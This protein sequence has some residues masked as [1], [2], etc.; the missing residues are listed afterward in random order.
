MNFVAGT[1]SPLHLIG[2]GSGQGTHIF[3]R[4]KPSP[5]AI[6]L[7]PN[8]EVKKRVPK[9]GPPERGVD[10]ASACVW[11]WAFVNRRRGGR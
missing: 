5:S 10:A 2:H 9:A 3:L 11:F 6:R 8:S 4:R 7:N 1:V